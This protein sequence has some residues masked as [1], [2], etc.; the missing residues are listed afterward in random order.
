MKKVMVV[1]LMLLSTIAVAKDKSASDTAKQ[2]NANLATREKSLSNRFKPTQD[3]FY[4]YKDR[5]DK[6]NNYIAA[7]WM[8]D[9]GDL[10]FNPGIP[11]EGGKQN[12]CI[13]VKVSMER[14]QGAGWNGIYWQH[15]A[16][17]WGDRK[18][19]YD[20]SS[21]KKLTFMARGEKGGEFIDKFGIGGITG[22]TEEGDSDN[23]SIENVELTKEWKTYSVDLKGLDLTHVIGGFLFAVNDDTNN[24]TPMAFYL[25]E[26]K[27]EK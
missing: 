4:I 6:D 13:Q 27:L 14:K 22:Q 2:V 17:N 25:D 20:L 16:N 11:V 7:G 1:S 19:G 9:Y 5:G 10:K 12:T 18:G 8:G 26:I 24:N 21:Y 23:A 15:P 3:V